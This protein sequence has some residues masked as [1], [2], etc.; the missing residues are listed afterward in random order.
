VV[1]GP[2]LRPECGGREHQEDGS[3]DDEQKIPR[4]CR[5]LKRWPQHL[6]R[7][8]AI[9]RRVIIFLLLHHCLHLAGMPE[10]ISLLSPL[11]SITT[12][13]PSRRRE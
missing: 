2:A 7:E 12:R 6:C 8:R 9:A 1:G 10:V 4:R 3:R 13:W 5:I 11:F